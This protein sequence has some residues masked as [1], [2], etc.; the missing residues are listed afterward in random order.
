M[1]KNSRKT[2]GH[3]QVVRQKT[4]KILFVQLVVICCI[5][6]LLSFKS[7]AI[8]YSALLGG[9]IYLLP[10]SYLANRILTKRRITDAEN[11]PNRALA[12][13][14]IGQI[15]KMVITAMLFALVFVLVKPLSPFS[16]FGTYIAIQ[17]LGWWLQMRADKRF[18]KL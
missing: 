17:A 7:W 4:L 3:T 1:L 6:L 2:R 8:G 9:L 14:Y 13:L 15:W 10:Y 12:E 16:L 5:A 18:I 11:T